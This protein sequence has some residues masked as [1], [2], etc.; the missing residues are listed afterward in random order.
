M[1]EYDI[2]DEFAEYLAGQVQPG[3]THGH[4]LNRLL[5]LDQHGTGQKNLTPG[6]EEYLTART[7]PVR[8]ATM[9]SAGSAGSKSVLIS[10]TTERVRRQNT[11][12]SLSHSP[13]RLAFAS[14]VIARRV[15]TARQTCGAI[16]HVPPAT[17][18]RRLFVL[19]RVRPCGLGRHRQADLPPRVHRRMWAQD[20]F[21]RHGIPVPDAEIERGKRYVMYRIAQA[22]GKGDNQIDRRA[23][24]WSGWKGSVV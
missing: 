4:V 9:C 11:E 19:A 17:T 1:R 21:Q 5:G 15:S 24:E 14:C 23:A 7:C 18:R 22:I 16:I 12:R 10:M 3:E 6:L 13:R 20:A 2:S 8:I